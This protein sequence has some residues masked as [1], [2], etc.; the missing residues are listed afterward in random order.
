M[1]ARLALLILIAALLSAC[2]GPPPGEGCRSCH[3]PH[4]A[5]KGTCVSCHRGNGRSTRLAI[6]H[7]RL[8]PAELS[9]FTIPG[10]VRVEEGKR[11][12]ERFG[13]RRC[14]R[15]G[16]KGTRLAADLDRLAGDDPVRLFEAIR[17]PVL[18][19]PDFRFDDRRTADVVNAIMAFAGAAPAQ[20]TAAVP[21]V[22]HFEAVR[23]KEDNLF[24]TKCGGCHRLLTAGEGGLGAGTVAPNLSGLFSPFYP[25]PFKPDEP[26]TPERL[27]RWLDNPRSV[28]PAALMSPVPLTKEEK[29]KLV[30]FL[31]ADL[32]N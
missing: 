1:V 11:V 21:L 31:R 14:H 15:L 17:Q 2:V 19:M 13:C 29:A 28:R 22:V 30:P 4:H 24:V 27:G 23:A 5:E 7:Y 6:A 18:F 32:E 20:G 10:S 25:T 9:H 26:W 12:A 8:V 3:R 16:E